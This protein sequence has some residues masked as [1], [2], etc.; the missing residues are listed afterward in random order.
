M[1]EERNRF[2]LGSEVGG[3]IGGRAMEFLDSGGSVFKF[4]QLR[5]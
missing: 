2:A 1:T 3:R 5:F 4:G